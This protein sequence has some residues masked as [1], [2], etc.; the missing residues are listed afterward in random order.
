MEHLSRKESIKLAILLVATFLGMELY[1]LLPEKHYI[2]F[3]PFSPQTDESLQWYAKDISFRLFVFF[4]CLWSWRREKER[5]TQGARIVLI[6][7]LF[8]GLEFAVYL[9][10]HS[11][12]GAINL[13]IYIPILIYGTYIIF[14]QQIWKAAEWLYS[15]IKGNGNND[16]S[17][18][19]L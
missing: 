14:G 18:K 1:Q 9:M 13:I 16:D 6:F 5:N 15:K 17:H 2:H 11:H 8:W 4:F 7:P 19:G 12:R 3:Y 10:C